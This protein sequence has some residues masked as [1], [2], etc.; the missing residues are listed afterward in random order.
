MS[1]RVAVVGHVEWVTFA[2]TARLPEPGEILSVED[3]FALAGGGGGVAAVRLAELAGACTFF[4]S[5]GRDPVGDR[6]LA[7]LEQ[8]GVDVRA[9][10]FD[11]PQRQAFTYLTDDHERT[12]TVWGERHVPRRADDLPWDEVADFDAVFFTGGDPEAL[13]AARDA[14]VLTA[15]PRAI[16]AIAAAG[17]ELDVL[18]AS[19][20]D[21]GERVDAASL[22]PRPRHVVLTRGAEG[23]RWEG[24][25]GEAGHW[26][27]AALPGP[28]VDAYGCGDTFAAA[29]TYGLGSGRSLADALELAAGCGAAV[30]TGRG[31]YAA[32]LPRT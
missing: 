30:L 15:T 14:R 1:P 19:A 10:R 7:D 32:P 22:R 18:I 24:A 28:P 23:G 12:I 17:V 9:A 11:G 4:T 20:T 3:G 25:T 8:R 5:V 6:T 21:R 29:L 16:G 27:A 13:R 2:V 31:P 26:A